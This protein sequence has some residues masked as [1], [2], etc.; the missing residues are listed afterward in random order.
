MGLSLGSLLEIRSYGFVYVARLPAYLG[1]V[2]WGEEESRPEVDGQVGPCGGRAAEDV[3]AVV[4]D[5]GDVGVDVAEPVH[6]EQRAQGGVPVEP[7]VVGGHAGAVA[8]AEQVEGTGG[9]ELV[10][11]RRAHVLEQLQWDD[12]E[13][14][15]GRR[16]RLAWWVGM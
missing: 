6:D 4:Q 16:G 5:A 12:R 9:V 10:R 14:E 15:G 7:G 13:A 11:A 8:E 2:V 3:H 1:E